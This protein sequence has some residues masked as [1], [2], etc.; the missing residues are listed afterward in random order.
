MFN[1]MELSQISLESVLIV[2][3][4]LIALNLVFIGFY[5][6][7]VLRELRKTVV[8]ARQIMEDVDRSVK[9]GVDKVISIERPLQA[10]AATTNALAGFIKGAE[11]IKKATSSILGSETKT[12]STNNSES[13][14]TDFDIE[15]SATPEINDII[16]EESP[17]KMNGIEPEH[18]V[19]QVASSQKKA[20]FR[21]P[22]FFKPT[23]KSPQN[24]PK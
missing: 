6:V 5:I 8:K 21:A 11:I 15:E 2:I 9:D 23:K 18:T 19:S 20:G 24:Q 4:V 14:V 3:I 12:T 16:E 10:L 13:I 17:F 22:S 7:S 1:Q